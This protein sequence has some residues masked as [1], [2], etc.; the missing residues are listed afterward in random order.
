MTVTG[1]TKDLKQR[2]VRDK[3]EPR[4]DESFALQISDTK[5]YANIQRVIT[6]CRVAMHCKP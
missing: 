6:N 3:E 4:K 5:R 1:L 2:W